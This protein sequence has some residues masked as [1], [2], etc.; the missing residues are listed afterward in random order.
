VTILKLVRGVPS[1]GRYSPAVPT[2]T[3]GRPLPPG[4]YRLVLTPRNTAGQAGR[5][6]M[7]GVVLVKR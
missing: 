4:R 5:A 7:L 2:R 6:R 1:A 3:G